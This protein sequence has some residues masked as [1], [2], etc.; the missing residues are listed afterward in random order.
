MVHVDVYF[1]ARMAKRNDPVEDTC[2]A[3]LKD[4][5]VDKARTET[6]TAQPFQI[7]SSTLGTDTQ[8]F[9]ERVRNLEKVGVIT[10]EEIHT[11]RTKTET[12][13]EEIRAV[14]QRFVVAKI[15][16]REA[17][18]VA[19]DMKQKRDETNLEKADMKNR[20]EQ[21]MIAKKNDEQNRASVAKSFNKKILEL[22]G[23]CKSQNSK[24]TMMEQRL[25]ELEQENRLLKSKS[26]FLA[27]TLFAVNL[28]P[29]ESN[30]HQMLCFSCKQPYSADSVMET[31]CQFHPLPGL[32]PNS[33]HRWRPG[34][35]ETF[36]KTKYAGYFYWPCCNT[37]SMR[38]PDGCCKGQHHQK[39]EMDVVMKRVMLSQETLE[40][41]SRME[42][43]RII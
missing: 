28:R 1:L 18:A 23:V 35:G 34:P 41:M 8:H 2:N 20:I 19:V 37:L 31:E 10:Q 9:E 27:E 12:L 32:P 13:E 39:W 25:K 36:R 5:S 22:R 33:W 6:S 26:N 3:F 42:D 40:E 43:T 4:F 16:Q 15:R 29:D 17:E 24:L 7:R 11:L 14:K 38:R 30:H 21:L